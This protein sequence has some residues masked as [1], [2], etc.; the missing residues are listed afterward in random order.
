MVIQVK[1][2]YFMVK[3]LNY[4]V[5]SLLSCVMK[6]SKDQYYYIQTLQ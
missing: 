6:L 2:R 5:M 1:G 3:V 4:N